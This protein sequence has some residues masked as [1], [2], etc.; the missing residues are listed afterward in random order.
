MG[1]KAALLGN[2]AL[3]GA[4]VLVALYLLE[5][6][7]RVLTPAPP[8]LITFDWLAELDMRRADP[9][10]ATYLPYLPKLE[11]FTAG[12]NDPEAPLMPFGLVSSA[13]IMFCG[14]R[15]TG[16]VVEYRSDERGFRNPQGI[17]DAPPPVALV[18]DSYTHGFCVANGDD[19]GGRL[20]SLGHP[21]LNLGQSASG[22]L[23]ALGTIVEYVAPIHPREVLWL[24][25]E[26]NDLRNL[27]KEWQ[28]PALQ[29]YLTDDTG[30]GTDRV[31]SQGLLERQAEVDAVLREFLEGHIERQRTERGTGPPA[32]EPAGDSAGSG[33]LPYLKLWVLRKRLGLTDKT[34]RES[35]GQAAVVF[36]RA[37]EIVRGW[38]GRLTVVYLPARRRYRFGARGDEWFDRPG[39]LAV[40][41]SLD[42]P[43]LDLT[44]VFGSASNRSSL[45]D[46]GTGYHYT[47]EGYRLVA[48]AIAEWLEAPGGT[49]VRD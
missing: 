21:V 9:S 42:I 31:A 46:P 25:Y 20:R 8:E 1:G 40:L 23:T 4:S 43:T 24:Y 7:A 44:D 36:A 15:L 26:G 12:L 14:N 32:V 30:P 37:A 18:G 2:L 10:V 49:L 45:F 22:P 6:L 48:E 27:R 39:V 17:W 16:E 28:V 3:A 33:L 47:R 38:D 29:S 19:V 5:G 41:D 11:T 13:R 34:Y 35:A